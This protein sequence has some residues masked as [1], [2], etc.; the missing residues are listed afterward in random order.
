MRIW[1]SL[2]LHHAILAAIAAFAAAAC[3]GSGGTGTG[4][5]DTT[6]TTT[7]VGGETT[8][9]STTSS[10]SSTTTTGTGG[11]CSGTFGDGSTCPGGDYSL[12]GP[13]ETGGSVMA[14]IVDE[15]GAPVPNQPIFICGTDLC[16]PAATTGADGTASIST[17]TTMKNRAF[18]FGDSL[19]YAELS[20]PLKLAAS[21]FMTLAT[22]KLSDK[23]G[24]DLQPGTD[25][26]SGDVTISIPSDASVVIPLLIYDTCEAQK[27]RTVSIPLTNLGPVLDPVMVNGSP[28]GFALVYGLAPAGTTVC[29]AA[30]VTVALP[31][32]TMTPNDLG[33]TPGADVEFW[34]TTVDPS[35]VYA[36][37]AGWA[38]ASDGKVSADGM[39][40]STVDGGGLVFL[41]N[42]AVRLKAP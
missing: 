26:T 39:T 42:F 22:G 38:K 16:S 23:P 32:K 18:K 30:K 19:A 25:A 12:N 15:T 2:R 31:H 21:T 1:L 17:S 4:G 11:D 41:D 37:Y 34:I 35:G 6:S 5:S 9:T 7:G 10:T 8:S 14:K 28:A 36:P 3:G 29:P 24:A 20:I 13:T 33:W 40:A 27:L